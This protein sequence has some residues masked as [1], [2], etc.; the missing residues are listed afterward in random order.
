MTV[1]NTITKL[2]YS[3]DG[4]NRQFGVTFPLLS[5]AHLR[6]VVTDENGVETE[7]NKNF[8]VSPMLNSVTYP[9]EESGLAPLAQGQKITLI[10]NTPLTQEID[11]QTGGGLDAQTLEAG[12][13]KLLLCLQEMKEQN[14][15]TLKFPVSSTSGQTD[16]TA[17]LNEIIAGVAQANENAELA[18]QKAQ[19]AAQSAQA[20]AQSETACSNSQQNALSS[21]QS[22]AQSEIAALASAQNSELVLQEIK[23]RVRKEFVFVAGTPSGSYDGSLTKINTGVDLTDVALCVYLNGQRKEN[24]KE[25]TVSGSSILFSFSLKEGDRVMAEVSGLLKTAQEAD[26][27]AEM[28]AHNQDAQA[29]PDLLARIEALEESSGG[30][31]AS[32]EKS[33]TVTGGFWQKTDLQAGKAGSVRFNLGSASAQI[34]R[35]ELFL[36][37]PNAANGPRLKVPCIVGWGGREGN[38][39]TLYWEVRL[40][41]FISFWD[42]YDNPAQVNYEFVVYYK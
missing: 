20:A 11:L 2:Q 35:A 27:D 22:A 14:D 23:K 31:S 8:A 41:E 28:S 24:P 17:Y 36:G 38:F 21:A 13:D 26:M 15:R 34:T 1:S 33:L 6:I 37:L 7:I 29:H 10:R 19:A 39:V 4:A 3:G 18:T 30:G 40:G 12:Y 42:W 9:T 32:Q 5:A 16:A 25:F